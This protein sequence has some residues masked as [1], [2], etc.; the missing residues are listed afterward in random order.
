MSVGTETGFPLH[1]QNGQGHEAGTREGGRGG[2]VPTE[3]LMDL[4]A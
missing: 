4:L 3:E 2:K 1:L